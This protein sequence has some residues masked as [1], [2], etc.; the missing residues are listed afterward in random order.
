MQINFYIGKLDS[1]KL[2]E[3]D[4]A[5]IISLGINLYDLKRRFYIKIIWK[6]KIEVLTR[7][8]IASYGMVARE[9]LKRVGNLDI[10]NEQFGEIHINTYRIISPNNIEEYADVVKGKKI[11][12]YSFDCEERIVKVTIKNKTRRIYLTLRLLEQC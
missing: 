1:I 12:Y 11:K 5:L 3:I 7:K 2:E 9:H 4:R 10:S 8:Q 6:R